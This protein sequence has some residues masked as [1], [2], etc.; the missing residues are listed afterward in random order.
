MTIGQQAETETKEW[1]AMDEEDVQV[2]PEERPPASVGFPAM[3]F[4]RATRTWKMRLW[5]CL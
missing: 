3:Q 5:N 2:V 4:G 1:G